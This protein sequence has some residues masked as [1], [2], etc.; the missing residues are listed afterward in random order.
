MGA[1]SSSS[2]S[3]ASARPRSVAALPAASGVEGQHYR[4]APSPALQVRLTD[5]SAHAGDGVGEPALVRGE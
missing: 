4:G 2:V 1:P 5:G 3:L